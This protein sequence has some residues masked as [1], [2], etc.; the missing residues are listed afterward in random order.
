MSKTLLGQSSN[1]NFVDIGKKEFTSKNLKFFYNIED[2]IEKEHPNTL[3]IAN[4]IQYLEKP[5]KFLEKLLSS[6]MEIVIF[7][8]LSLS[9][10]LEFL[11]RQTVPPSIY[12]ASYPCWF[13]DKLK[14]ENIIEKFNYQEIE[15]F[16][17]QLNPPVKVGSNYGFFSGKILTLKD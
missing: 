13:L 16:D 11:T 1:K 7:D 6:K 14:I 4:T 9:K 5:Y 17:S 15:S 12:K 8:N 2:C 10:G 3:I